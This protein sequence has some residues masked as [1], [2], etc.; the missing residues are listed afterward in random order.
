VQF[1]ERSYCNQHHSLV[2]VH[3]LVLNTWVSCSLSCLNA[4]VCNFKSN[5]TL[6]VLQPVGAV[7][8]RGVCS[9][10]SMYFLFQGDQVPSPCIVTAGRLST[11]QLCVRE[12]TGRY[13]SYGHNLIM[14]CSYSDHWQ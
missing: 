14:L 4:G 13:T 2:I 5:Q 12:C 7:Y 6:L 10:V 3:Q 11:V 1:S 8:R 9:I